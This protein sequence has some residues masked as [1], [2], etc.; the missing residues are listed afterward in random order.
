MI[1]KFHFHLKVFES[2]IYCDGILWMLSVIHYGDIIME[3]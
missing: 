3:C 1:E 2:K